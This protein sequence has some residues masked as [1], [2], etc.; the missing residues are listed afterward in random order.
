[1]ACDF[2]LRMRDVLLVCVA[3][4]GGFYIGYLNASSFCDPM[5]DV[6]VQY[7]IAVISDGQ[8]S[9]TTTSHS[10]PSLSIKSDEPT[11]PFDS[12]PSKSSLSETTDRATDPPPPDITSDDSDPPSNVSSV[13]RSN[14]F[15]TIYQWQYFKN[16][17]TELSPY[18]VPEHKIIFCGIPKNAISMWKMVL[19]RLLRKK[20]WLTKQA[21][22]HAFENGLAEY[23]WS[24]WLSELDH[25]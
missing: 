13:I 5:V 20:W 22:I 3:F 25:Q 23:R 2:T 7:P 17:N 4:V 1:M 14:H 16:H 11:D 24:I 15:D 10:D 8:P 19:L 21:E 6:S 9:L 18:F 12:V